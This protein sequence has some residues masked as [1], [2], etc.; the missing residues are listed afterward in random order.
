MAVARGVP[1]S[2]V[3]SVAGASRGTRVSKPRPLGSWTLS[4][5]APGFYQ[6]QGYDIATTIDCEPPG[7]VHYY[8]MKRLVP[9]RG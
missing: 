7:L 6:K 8:M 9:P 2:W 5:Q 3:W 4:T 1:G